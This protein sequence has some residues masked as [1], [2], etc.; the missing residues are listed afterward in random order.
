MLAL[1]GAHKKVS[2][3]AVTMT[4]PV[5]RV[6]T[7]V[8]A[9]GCHP[10]R[11][12]GMANRSTPARPMRSALHANAP[13]RAPRLGQAQLREHQLGQMLPGPA[14]ERTSHLRRRHQLHARVLE[15]GLL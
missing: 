1:A 13:A 6:T 15:E 11:A 9:P 2:A 7:T 12:S 14:C 8:S 5:S 3:A 10:F 4:I